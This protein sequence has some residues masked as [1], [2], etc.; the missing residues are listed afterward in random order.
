MKWDK[1]L[2]RFAEADALD[3]AAGVVS[4]E[5]PAGVFAWIVNLITNDGLVFSTP[6]RERVAA[7]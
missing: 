4:A 1:R 7:K 5:L 3:A 2:W 6:Y